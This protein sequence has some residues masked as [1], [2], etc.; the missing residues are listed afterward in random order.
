MGDNST[1]QSGTARAARLWLVL[2]L[3]LAVMAFFALQRE[4]GRFDAHA[5]ATA[6]AS[7]GWKPIFA[8][9]ACA[10]ASFLALGVFELL[11]LRDAATYKGCEPA[12]KVPAVAAMTTSFVA[13]AF[14]QSIGLAI[15]TGS[16]VRLRAYARYGV[17]TAAVAR[18]SGFVT[19]TA[20]LGLLSAGGVAFL[21]GPAAMTFGHFAL[22]MRTIGILLMLPAIAY[23]AWAV[24]GKGKL[25]VR[26]WRMRPPSRRLAFLQVGL[27][28]IDWLLTG[29]VLFVLLPAA[30]AIGYLAF[31]GVYLI[32]QT[33]GVISHVPGGIGVFEGA[34]LTLLGAAIT[35]PAA[36]ALAASLIVY[37]VVYY[38]IPLVAATVVATLADL[39]PGSK[40]LSVVP[41]GHAS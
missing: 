4:L 19:L 28:V 30:A 5:F 15:V 39:R 8:A 41:I 38:L 18:I 9:V 12:G 24:A 13:N 14:S 22:S 37:R 6:I 27:S 31:L 35:L 36:G 17:G 40:K 29:T 25:A 16:A 23:L 11:A 3:S 26:S 34:F 10:F 33:A 32:A 7:Y 2:R 1:R 20:T 21:E